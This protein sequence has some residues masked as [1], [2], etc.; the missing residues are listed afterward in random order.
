MNT[1]V[2]EAIDNLIAVVRRN[3]SYQDTY[4]KLFF[5]AS[6]SVVEVASRSPEDLKRDG[7]SMKNLRGEFIK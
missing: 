6:E 7:I 5:N 1:E 4:F 3:S 2:N